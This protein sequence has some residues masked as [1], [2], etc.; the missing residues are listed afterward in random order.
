MSSSTSIMPACTIH[1]PVPKDILPCDTQ[2]WTMLMRLLYT[3]YVSRAKMRLTDRLARGLTNDNGIARSA[4]VSAESGSPIRHRI[5]ARLPLV[6]SRTK[7]QV[8][9]A[10]VDD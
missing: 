3:M 1:Q 7:A 5:S 6:R 4:S 2:A 8:D 9:I 10:L